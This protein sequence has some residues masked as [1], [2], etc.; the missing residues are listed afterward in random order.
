MGELSIA[1]FD[2]QRVDVLDSPKLK[3]VSLCSRL[4]SYGLSGSSDVSNTTQ[5]DSAT[6][7]TALAT[8]FQVVTSFVEAPLL[9]VPG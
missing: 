6:Y 1:T 7:K 5:A 8:G 4:V 9:S 3:L 2:Y